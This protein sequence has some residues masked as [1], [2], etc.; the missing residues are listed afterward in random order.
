[1]SSVPWTEIG[2]IA[3]TAA[4]IIALIS[5]LIGRLN[6]ADGEL[7]RQ[8]R[9]DNRIGDRVKRI[10][11]EESESS[12]VGLMG[13]IASN[14]DFEVMDV[15]VTENSGWVYLLKK[16]IEGFDGTTELDICSQK[17]SIAVEGPVPEMPA[18]FVFIEEFDFEAYDVDETIDP[19]R[20]LIRLRFPHS[21]IDEIE[22]TVEDLLEFM[23]ENLGAIPPFSYEEMQDR[24]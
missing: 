10:E 12:G 3:A 14:Y 1:M 8:N 18:D 4:A 11:Y 16:I 7:E 13:S 17:Y 19:E 24:E 21:D 23:A 22:R 2:T 20:A 15:L 9:I 5:A 6:Y